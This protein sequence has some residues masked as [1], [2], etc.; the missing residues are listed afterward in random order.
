MSTLL[1][2]LLV[3]WIMR[4]TTED[5]FRSIRWTALLSYMEDLDWLDFTFCLFLVVLTRVDCFFF[6]SIYLCLFSTSP[7][8]WF[9]AGEQGV[10]LELAWGPRNCLRN[11]NFVSLSFLLKRFLSFMFLFVL[12]SFSFMSIYLLG[13]CGNFSDTVV[14]SCRLRFF[15]ILSSSFFSF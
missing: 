9:E 11:L 8:V 7:R 15:S 14:G 2:N 4:R 6:L 1:F 3:N 5:Q 10:T 12:P 13:L